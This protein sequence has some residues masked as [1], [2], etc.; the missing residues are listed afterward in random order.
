MKS[1]D[2]DK[3]EGKLKQAKGNI[4]EGAGKLVGDSSLETEGKVDAL[5]G[6]AQEKRGEVK[7]V[8]GA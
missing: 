5:K 6:K 4:K 7:K 3:A 8:F 1:S 2:R